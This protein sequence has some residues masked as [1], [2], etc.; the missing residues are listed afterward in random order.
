MMLHRGGTRARRVPCLLGR[1]PCQLHF[2]APNNSQI[3]PRN[4]RIALPRAVQAGNTPWPFRRT[5]TAIPHRQVPKVI[6]AS[7]HRKG[8]SLGLR[9]GCREAPAL[10]R[11][12]TRLIPLKNRARRSVAA[13][14]PSQS[15]RRRVALRRQKLLATSSQRR[16]K[17]RHLSTLL[18]TTDC[19]AAP[20]PR[21]PAA[22]LELHLRKRR[23]KAKSD[24]C[25]GEACRLSR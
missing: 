24:V 18:R 1:T 16:R 13:D 9:S 12:R 4:Q 15:S 5:S 19:C 10:P 2:L 8:T 3:F 7:R 6:P 17:L 25:N 21:R 22:W 20:T 11:H 23:T 14:P